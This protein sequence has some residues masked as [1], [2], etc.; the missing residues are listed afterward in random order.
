MWALK[1]TSLSSSFISPLKKRDSV[2]HRLLEG[3]QTWK[4]QEMPSLGRD[5]D[6]DRGRWLWNGK[7]G[8][9]VSPSLFWSFVTDWWK[10]PSCVRSPCGLL[11]CSPSSSQGQPCTESE[12]LVSFSHRG[13]GLHVDLSCLSSI[14]LV[15]HFE[16]VNSDAPSVR[17]SHLVHFCHLGQQ[18]PS[19]SEESKLYNHRV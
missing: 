1:F 10:S 8:L 6:K 17:P 14:V 13:F 2:Y 15:L 16:S 18:I 12:G 11:L 19:F 3:L 4:R 9:A 5:Q 7:V